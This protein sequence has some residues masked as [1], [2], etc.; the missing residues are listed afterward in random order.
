MEVDVYS[1]EEK[2]MLEKMAPKMY[3][4]LCAVESWCQATGHG[5]VEDR[6]I[7]IRQSVHS[8]LGKIRTPV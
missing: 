4:T 5:S 8:V 1:D 6:M 3:Q 7:N 2:E